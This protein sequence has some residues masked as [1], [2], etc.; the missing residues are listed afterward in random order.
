MKSDNMLRLE[1]ELQNM[2]IRLSYAAMRFDSGNYG[3]YSS[4]DELEALI[5]I[6][7]SLYTEYWKLRDSEAS[8]EVL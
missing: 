7:R 5:P 6:C 1:V 2:S 8:N 3:D 4:L